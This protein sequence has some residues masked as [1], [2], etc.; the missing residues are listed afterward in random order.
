MV[1]GALAGRIGRE[2]VLFAL[3]GEGDFEIHDAR[4]N[5][6]AFVFEID[7]ENFVHAGEGNHK[8]A[9]SRNRATAQAGSGATANQRDTEL[10]RDASDF[11]DFGRCAREHD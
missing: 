4:L 8:A 1:A 10:M 7:G 9:V 5:H 2:E 6:G 11:R 3:H